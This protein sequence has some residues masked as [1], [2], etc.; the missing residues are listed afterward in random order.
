MVETGSYELFTMTV[1]QAGN[2]LQG[3]LDAITSINA[4]CLTV[5]GSLHYFSQLAGVTPARS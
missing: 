5:L 1:Y 2:G 4:H 3:L